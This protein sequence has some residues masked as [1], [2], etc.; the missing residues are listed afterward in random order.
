MTDGEGGVRKLNCD[1]SKSAG[2]AKSFSKMDD[3]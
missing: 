1:G 2:G 3:S